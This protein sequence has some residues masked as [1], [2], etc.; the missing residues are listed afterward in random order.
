MRRFPLAILLSIVVAVPLGCGGVRAK[1]MP[2]THGLIDLMRQ[3]GEA[4]SRDD[5]ESF[6]LC[7]EGLS[8]FDGAGGRLEDWFDA[9]PSPELAL[10][11]AERS[12]RRARAIECRSW[13]RAIGLHRDAAA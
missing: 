2:A 7:R 11:L 12:Y 4:R 9:H 10:V 3:P 1:R 8:E 13:G 6:V 5:L